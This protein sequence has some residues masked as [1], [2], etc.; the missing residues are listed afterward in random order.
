MTRGIVAASPRD[1]RT[2]PYSKYVGVR[3]VCTP[4]LYVRYL[5]MYCKAGVRYTCCKVQTV[6]YDTIHTVS[7]SLPDY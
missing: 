5:H 2:L 4:Y 6:P 1:V 3:Y 7:T